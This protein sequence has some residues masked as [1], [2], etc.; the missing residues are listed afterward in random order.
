[1]H[2]KND[3]P[4]RRTVRMLDVKVATIAWENAEVF[5]GDE[6]GIGAT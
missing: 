3:S 1:M 6:G 5:E 2:K 4:S